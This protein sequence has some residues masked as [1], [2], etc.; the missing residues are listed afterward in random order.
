MEK[1]RKQR[2]FKKITSDIDFE[3]FED[4]FVDNGLTA[5]RGF[6]F[7]S[8]SFIAVASIGGYFAY[9]LFSKLSKEKDD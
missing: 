2:E 7:L 4:D 6:N 9:F 8:F 5:D 1:E 3:D